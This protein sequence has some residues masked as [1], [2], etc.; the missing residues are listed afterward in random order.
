MAPGGVP[1]QG[2]GAER[3]ALERDQPHLAELLNALDAAQALVFQAV[4]SAEADLDPG[5]AADTDHRLFERIVREVLTNPEFS[6]GASSEETGEGGWAADSQIPHR[7][8]VTLERAGAFRRDLL[9]LFASGNASDAYREVEAHVDEY[10]GGSETSL[11]ADPKDVTWVKSE[12]RPEAAAFREAYPNLHG[13]LWAQ[14]WL[15]LA[16]FEPLIRYRNPGQRR[17]GVSAV[18]A[19]FWSLLTRPPESF[20]TEMPLA[21]TVARTLVA[22]HSDAAAILDNAN[23]FRETIMDIL[24][25][26]PHAESNR[27]LEVALDQFQDPESHTVSWYDWNRTAILSGV[28]N[29]GGLA[30]GI[31]TNPQDT[32]LRLNESRHGAGHMVM[33]GMPPR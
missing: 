28:G 2:I 17:A 27:A 3:S 6:P 16:A 25:R 4:A 24:V 10:L 21:P 5:R 18:V 12:D 33:P 31:L 30:T 7:A 29:Q 15:Q 11:L 20:P 32:E 26:M 1:A 8:R 19:R 9:N 22:R 14:Q 13:L 23:M